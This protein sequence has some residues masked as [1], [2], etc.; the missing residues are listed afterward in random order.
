MDDPCCADARHT[1]A[2]LTSVRMWSCLEAWC[3]RVACVSSLIGHALLIC[4]LG[5]KQRDSRRLQND[6]ARLACRRLLNVGLGVPDSFLG[7]D[8]PFQRAFRS[9]CLLIKFS[10]NYF[11]I[12]VLCFGFLVHFSELVSELVWYSQQL[13][14]CFAVRIFG[15]QHQTIDQDSAE[16]SSTSTHELTG[17]QHLLSD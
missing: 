13:Q 3:L 6:G 7:W 8:Q 4:P 16:W 10:R 17:L 2:L 9:L 5:E 15:V 1:E 14:W 11:E 12:L